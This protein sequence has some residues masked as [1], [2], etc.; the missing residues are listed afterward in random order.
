MKT[1]TLLAAAL[2]SAFALPFA[3]N[4]GGSKDH[5]GKTAATETT[6]SGA[7]DVGSRATF[8]SIDKDGDGFI[9]KTESAGSSND[10]HFAQLDRNGDGKLSSA[11][12]AGALDLS[13]RGTG[14]Y[15]SPTTS[16]TTSGARVN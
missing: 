15:D 16:G 2:A 1:R 9:S 3:V 11:E 4:A 5:G 14:S 13:T 7:T 8:A 10:A 12:H 6:T